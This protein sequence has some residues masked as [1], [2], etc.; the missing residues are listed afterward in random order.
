MDIYVVV[1]GGYFV[2]HTDTTRVYKWKDGGGYEKGRARMA[3]G[4]HSRFIAWVFCSV[5]IMDERLG[6]A[7]FRD[8]AK[9]M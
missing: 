5:V 2:P 1:V 4:V 8:E 9:C 6:S 3:T 7:V